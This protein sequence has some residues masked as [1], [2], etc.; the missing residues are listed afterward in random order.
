LLGIRAKVDRNEKML[1]GHG[2]ALSSCGLLESSGTT[3]S[4]ILMPR[5]PEQ[6]QA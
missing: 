4:P 5:R 3:F 2:A 6:R 1:C